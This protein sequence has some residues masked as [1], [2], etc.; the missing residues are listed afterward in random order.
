[1]RTTSGTSVSSSAQI[2]PGI[3]VDSDISATAGIA[4]SKLAALTASKPVLTDSSGFLVSGTVPATWGGTGLASPTA[5]GLLRAQG[6]SAMDLIAPGANGTVLKSNGTDWAAGVAP[7]ALQGYSAGGAG[8]SVPHQTFTAI[9]T[10]SSCPA[11]TTTSFYRIRFHHD[12]GTAHSLN[13]TY[14]YLGATSTFVWVNGS[15]SA[16]DIEVDV[17]ALNSTSS[18]K[19]VAR[20]YS[21][22]GLAKVDTGTSAIDLSSAFN[23]SCQIYQ[24]SGGSVTF[25]SSYGSA[26]LVLL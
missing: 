18:Q 15:S 19:W 25:T 22:T 6:A 1:M 9:R 7:G 26:E 2:A 16:L 21:T 14:I 3:I 10:L 12:N 8:V 11:M 13:R 17:F 23:I 5:K 20:A 24:E 4:V